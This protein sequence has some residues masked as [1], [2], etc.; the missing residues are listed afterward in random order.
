MT[1]S[2]FTEILDPDFRTTS[3]ESDVRLEDI[4]GAADMTTVRG[5]T[6]SETSADSNSSR[7]SRLGSGDRLDEKS[8]QLPLKR[9]SRIFS[10]SKR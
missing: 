7:S 5:R 9:R 2:K 6:S 10:L 3:P 8:T 4:I 1:S